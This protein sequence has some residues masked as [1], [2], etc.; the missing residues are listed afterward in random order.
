MTKLRLK[1]ILMILT[2]SLAI[3]CKDSENAAIADAGTVQSV[4]VP[5]MVTNLESQENLLSQEHEDLLFMWEEEKMAR[6]VYKRMYEK[7]GQAIFSSISNSE[8]KHMDSVKKL[9]DQRSLSLPVD[10]NAVG[11]FKNAQIAQLYQELINQGNT[12]L[13]EA[14]QVG[15]QIE[16]VDIEDLAKRIL[17]TQDFGIITVYKNLLEASYNHKGAFENKI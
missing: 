11:I 16:M 17:N 5:T 1:Y 12:S 4:T 8:Q 13:P 6:D 14:Y 10:A 2:L 15:L 9:L 7:Y 3:S